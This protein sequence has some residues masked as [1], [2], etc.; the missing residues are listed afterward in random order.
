MPRCAPTTSGRKPAR[1]WCERVGPLEGQPLEEVT[2]DQEAGEQIGEQRVAGRVEVHLELALEV[3]RAGSVPELVQHVEEGQSVARAER[4]EL[5]LDGA[6]IEV[7]LPEPA[8]FRG[9]APPLVVD[10]VARR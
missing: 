3:E 7:G 8:L 2:I 5:R 4:R 6:M 1:P 9:T 10:L